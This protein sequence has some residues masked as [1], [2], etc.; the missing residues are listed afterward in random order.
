MVAEEPDTVMDSAALA[1]RALAMLVES[2]PPA[3]VKDPPAYKWL[4]DT[5]S[6]YTGSFIPEPRGFQV[7]PSHLAIRLAGLPPAVVK[8][9]PAYRSLPETASA[10]PAAKRLPPS[11]EPSGLQL[12]P[13]HLALQPPAYTFLPETASACTGRFLSSP[14]GLQ[15]L[16]SHLAIRLAVSVGVT[17]PPAYRSLPETASAFTSSFMP[18]PGIALQLVPSH[19]AMF[20]AGIPPAVVKVPAA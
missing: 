18:E 8:W 1:M 7:V 5:A 20:K 15:L 6:A 19:L 4:P 2:L 12:L 13:F 3:V 9:P 10:D 11:P 17:W 14:S 16:P